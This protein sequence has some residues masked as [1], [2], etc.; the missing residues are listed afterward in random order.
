LLREADANDWTV[1]DLRAALVKHKRRRKHEELS[2][3]SL[4]EHLKGRY[5]LVYCDPPWRFETHSVLG[6]EMTS[7]DN[8]YE[9]MTVEE[10]CD[11][12]VDGR[13]MW[14]VA[15]DDC[16]LYL[17]TTAPLFM[18]MQEV[19]PRW[20]FEYKTHAMWD[21]EIPGTGYVFR[22]QHEILI[23]ATRGNMPAPLF[24]P[25]SVFR[26]KRGKHSA[27][28]PE[29]RQTLEKMYPMF[30]KNQRLEMF[31]RGEVPGWTVWGKEAEQSPAT[32]EAAPEAQSG[33]PGD[34]VKA[35]LMGQLEK[36][37]K[38]YRMNRAFRYRARQT[39]KGAPQ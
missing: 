14:E 4:D 21:K 17:W 25:P 36:Q 38:R 19:L 6:G 10:I 18:R 35:L 31:A 2:G 3:I 11:L 5:R 22:G 7:P 24:A 20:D 8:H 26:Y 32:L 33:A 13:T 16:A 28:P 12:I 1:R 9:T 37:H 30:G 29:I 15:D 34:N 27:K 39:A 23:Y